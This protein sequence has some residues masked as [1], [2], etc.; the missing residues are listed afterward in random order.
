MT[1]DNCLLFIESP[2]DPKGLDSIKFD[3]NSS[4]CCNVTKLRLQVESKELISLVKVSFRNSERKGSKRENRVVPLSFRIGKMRHFSFKIRYKF[5]ESFDLNKILFHSRVKGA[6]Y[7]GKVSFRYSNLTGPK[8][9]LKSRDFSIQ[10][11]SVQ[12]KFDSNS[13]VQ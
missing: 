12:L 3:R 7:E 13:T 9:C 10:L 2:S 1:K 11:K 6:D 4:N 8:R 5:S